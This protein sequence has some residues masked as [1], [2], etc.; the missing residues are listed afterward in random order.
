MIWRSPPIYGAEHVPLVEETTIQTKHNRNININVFSRILPEIDPASSLLGSELRLSE[1]I[2]SSD[3]GYHTQATDLIAIGHA[4]QYEI[5]GAE[6]RSIPIVASVA[7]SSRHLVRLSPLTS[8]LFSSKVFPGYKFNVSGVDTRE[9]GYYIDNFSPIMQL[10]F[11]TKNGRTGGFLAVRRDTGTIIL[12]PIWRQSRVDR[13]SR[14]RT[15]DLVDDVLHNLSEL[16]P[17]YVL[18]VTID[19]TEKLSHA[20]VAFN[21]WYERQFAI[22][23][24]AG[25]VSIFTLERPSRLNVGWMLITGPTFKIKPSPDVE[26]GS[27]E[28]ADIQWDGWA[29]LLWAG[30]EVTMIASTR[31][32]FQL[33]SLGEDH[34][35]LLKTPDILER[36]ED[37]VIL[38][39]KRDP[40]DATQV[41]VLTSTHAIWLRISTSDEREVAEEGSLSARVIVRLCHYRSPRDISI[42]LSVHRSDGGTFL[43]SS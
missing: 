36:H 6:V 29:A 42:R 34:I 43:K 10:C 20:D 26:E 15:D 23:N 28:E 27:T 38:D 21:P 18:E 30:D 13:P 41:Y 14:P 22:I 39:I 31:R 35:V 9:P 33:L 1:T 12:R 17:G 16:G 40:I 25:L 4:G 3:I 5:N 11:S 32:T 24:R 7:G 2:A 37:D 8:N 19:Q